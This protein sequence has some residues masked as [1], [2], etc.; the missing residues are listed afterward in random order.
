M[1]RLGSLRVEIALIGAATALLLAGCWVRL[2]PG[3][4]PPNSSTS[5]TPS[6]ET[7]SAARPSIPRPSIAKAEAAILKLAKSLY[8]AVPIKSANVS[9]IG[10]GTR[11][12]W[13]FQAWTDA[14]TK[15]QNE[16]WFVT[17]DGAKWA[18]KGHG[19]GTVRSDYPHD[20]KW[21]DVY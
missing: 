20:I 19:A 5:S 4:P 14:G 2:G 10:R 12:I 13:W 16:E 15:Y 6:V 17:W 11:G 3:E 9:G 18:L 7:T 1:R 8:P 21:E